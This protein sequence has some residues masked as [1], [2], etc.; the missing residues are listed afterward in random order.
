MNAAA[1]PRHLPTLTGLRGIA[2]IAVLLYH[3]RG[4]MTGFTPEWLIAV[5]AHGYLA[6]DLFFVLSGF[7]LWWTY[8]AAFRDQGR[9]AIGPFL[10]RRF[11]R[12][13]PLH[14]AIMAAMTAF[15]ALLHFSGRTS[16]QYPF[17]ELPAQLLLI[18]NWGLTDRLAWNDPAWSISAE[19]AAYLLLAL[20]GT[21][22]A[23][24]DSG[25][26]RFPL[27]ALAIAAALG[28]WFALTGRDSIGA[29][30]PATGLFRCIAEF[31]IGV[32]LCQWW[33]AYRDRRVLVLASAAG[34]AALGAALIA[35]GVSQPAGVPLIMAA[36]VIAGLE[37]SLIRHPLLGGRTAQWLGQI[38]YALYLS[39]FFWWILFKLLFVSD[40]GKLSA[41]AIAAFLAAALLIAHLLHHIVELP[42]RQRAQRAGDDLL[43]LLK[44]RRVRG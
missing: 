16:A 29:D 31:S 21:T 26:V 39:H 27:L 6:V 33:T 40:P 35:S 17:A 15:A 7:V 34:L 11:A 8:G 24:L 25:P 37:A 41:A 4:S 22:V 38:S 1:A 32:L 28:T 9:G 42:G 20:G 44:A 2:A 43:S 14:V 13:F 36:I 23:R 3:I 18:Q 10:V 19:W 5:L 12:I 30:I